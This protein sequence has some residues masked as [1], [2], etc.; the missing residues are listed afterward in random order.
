MKN[1]SQFIWSVT[2]LL[3]VFAS[4][5]SK[6]QVAIIDSKKILAE[7]PEIAKADSLYAKEFQKYQVAYQNFYSSTKASIKLVDSLNKIDPKDPIAIKTTQSATEQLAKL[8]ELEQESNTKL[9]DY[10]KTLLKPQL[11]K[12]NAAIK[13]I[14][15]EMHYK[16]VVDIQQ[17]N[18]TWFDPTTD[19]SDAVIK[20]IKVK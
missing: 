6:C 16:Q 8:K 15:T 9:S 18:F 5:S 1:S 14:A 7:I 13:D 17:V 12:I 11:D 10:K 19:I 3:L 4:I 2:T 20:K